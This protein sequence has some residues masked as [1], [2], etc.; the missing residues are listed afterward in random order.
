MK[1]TLFSIVIILLI[2]MIMVI[3]PDSIRLLYQSNFGYAI[4][5]GLILVTSIVGGIY[6]GIALL[7]LSIIVHYILFIYSP[8]LTS[9][10]SDTNI[11]NTII[12]RDRQDIEESIRPKESNSIQFFNTNRDSELIPY[13]RLD[14]GGNK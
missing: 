14:I 5:Y 11:T 3:N 4:L 12:G 2:G 9:L 6:S 13:N 7:I 10:Q 8:E 1:H